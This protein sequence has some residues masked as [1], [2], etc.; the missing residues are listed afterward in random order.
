M[1]LH[2]SSL[3]FPL[4]KLQFL[5]HKLFEQSS[6]ENPFLQAH[7]N[8]AIHSPFLKQSFLHLPYII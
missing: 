2:P 8:P 4:G 6:P 5:G 7:V 1:H 3:Q